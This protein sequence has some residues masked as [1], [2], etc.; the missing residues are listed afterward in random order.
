MHRRA[1]EDAA[2]VIDGCRRAAGDVE[3][4]WADQ[5]GSD[6][7]VHE[8]RTQREL[9]PVIAGWRCE[10]GEATIIAA[11]G[12]K[13]VWSSGFCRVVVACRPMK[14][15]SL[16]R[17]SGPPRV[18]PSWLRLRPS[19]LPDK[20]SACRKRLSRMNSNKLPC[21][22]LV[23]AFVTA[24]TEA[25]AR[26]VPPASTARDQPELLQR[27]GE[28]QV[29]AGAVEVV[30]MRCTVE[31]IRHS[32]VIAARDRDADAGVH[33][34]AGRRRCLH[35]D[36]RQ[37]DQLCDLSRV[38]RQF[39]DAFALDDSAYTSA[40]CVDERNCAHD[41]HLFGDVAEHQ[42]WINHGA[43]VDLQDDTSLR[44]RAELPWRAASTRYGPSGRF[45][46]CRNRFRW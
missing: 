3:R 20:K 18:P 24:F 9:S 34:V 23:P 36:A 16:S 41:S 32:E 14:K 1:P 30:Q 29:H 17:T 40:A 7:I 25:P 13:A 22:V 10:G 19:L 21:T 15:N 12:T 33:G 38:E 31:R 35:R 5:G 39:D 2:A 46:A 4:C 8:W 27:V 11:V 42:F 6:A 28:R 44:E 45:E 43:A 26:I 37:R